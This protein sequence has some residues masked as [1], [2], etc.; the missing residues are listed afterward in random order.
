MFK[1]RRTKHE[2]E[3]SRRKIGREAVRVTDNIH[4]FSRVQ[5]KTRIL[6]VPEK[7]PEIRAGNDAGTDFQHAEALFVT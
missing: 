3:R 5:I 2:V 6:R 4:V 7:L 1:D